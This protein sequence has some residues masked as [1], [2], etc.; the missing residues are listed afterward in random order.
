M[1]APD[2]HDLLDLSLGPDPAQRSPFDDLV[3]AK[4]AIRR[5]RVHWTVG[6]ATAVTSTALLTG[7]ALIGDASSPATPGFAAAPVTSPDPAVPTTFSA[8]DWL[9]RDST[10]EPEV[11][12]DEEA[13]ARCNSIKYT[14]GSPQGDTVVPHHRPI[15]AGDAVTIS[16]PELGVITRADGT[17]RP[18]ELSCTV[19]G[20]WIVPSLP[21]ENQLRAED[22]E[23]ILLACSAV[24]STDLRDWVVT[25]AMADG[26]SGL[27]ATLATAD[28]EAW[29]SCELGDGHREIWFSKQQSLA[30]WHQLGPGNGQLGLNMASLCEAD[31]N[32]CAGMIYSRSNVLPAGMESMVI[33]LGDGTVIDVPVGVD[34]SYAVRFVTSD[35][36]EP[37]VETYDSDGA[38][39]LSCL[40]SEC[41]A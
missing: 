32:S 29:A 27:N 30:E 38:L 31:P 5:R 35:I 41:P 34:G 7:I 36:D 1:P 2:L 37:I 22:T 11:V 26:Q 6:V 13:L 23:G 24:S 8:P 14:D 28:R 17:T 20:S 4:S 3:R 9:P 21:S 16:G 10:Y 33:R 40:Q 12:T 19:P 15:H 18:G 39:V 25:V